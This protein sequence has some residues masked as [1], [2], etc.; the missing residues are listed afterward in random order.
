MRELIV[1]EVTPIRFGKNNIIVCQ[2]T[3]TAEN[4]SILREKIKTDVRNS[5]NE[6]M[7]QLNVIYGI[8]NLGKWS[9]ATVKYFSGTTAV[10][11]L[12]DE[13]GAPDFDPSKMIARKIQGRDLI[14]EPFGEFKLIIYGIGPYVHDQEFC[15]IFDGLI[16]RQKVT[17]VF[18]LVE[19][20]LN[21]IHECYAG[22]LLY[23]FRSKLYSFREALIREKISYL[24]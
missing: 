15:M 19:K 8:R 14:V 17:C 7:L 24:A 23:A 6:E 4:L 9:R 3:K 5:P 2:R 11:Q 16:K 18:S 22:D 12:L 13:N 10:L 21:K 1:K 20:K